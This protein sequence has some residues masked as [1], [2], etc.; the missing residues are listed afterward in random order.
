MYVDFSKQ[1]ESKK[2]LTEYFTRLIE[3][4][5]DYAS[6]LELMKRIYAGI[7]RR[8][9]YDL[10]PEE[11]MQLATLSLEK[12]NLIQ[13]YAV[14]ITVENMSNGLTTDDLNTALINIENYVLN[15]TDITDFEKSVLIKL[16]AG[17][18]VENKF[19]DEVKTAEAIKV[20][21]E[22][23]EEVTYPKDMLFVSKGTRLDEKT[24]HLLMQGGMLVESRTDHYIMLLGLFILLLM[25]WGILHLYL[26]YFEKSVLSTTKKYGILMS[27]FLVFF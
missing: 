16:I 12:L 8:N 19:V 2:A 17:A 14:D 7:E 25:L 20:E 3:T 4:K 18:L 5:S 6:D 26:S 11:L 9:Q 13:N 24:H 22:K 10:T 27:L 23:I 15:Q 1:V 21:V